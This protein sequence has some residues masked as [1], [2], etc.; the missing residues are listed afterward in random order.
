MARR[1]EDRELAVLGRSATLPV[2]G[3]DVL[4]AGQ[5]GDIAVHV[6]PKDDMIAGLALRR[7]NDG[8]DEVLLGLRFSP[9]APVKPAEAEVAVS[10]ERAHAE[11]FG[12]PASACERRP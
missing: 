10:D 8:A 2:D 6:S 3:Q 11:T 7:P 1:V 4:G 5:E 9:G 12:S